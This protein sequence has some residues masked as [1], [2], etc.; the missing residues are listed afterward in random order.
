[1][2][3]MWERFHTARTLLQGSTSTWETMQLALVIDVA[4]HRGSAKV[5]CFGKGAALVGFARRVA[6]P[7]RADFYA[8]NELRSISYV[9]VVQGQPFM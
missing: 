2:R 9:V 4:R 3:R 5:P 7:Q 6:R 8:C 1:M